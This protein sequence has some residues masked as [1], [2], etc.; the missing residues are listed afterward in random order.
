MIPR[1]RIEELKDCQVVVRHKVRNGA[2]LT[3]TGTLL[4]VYARRLKLET[5]GASGRYYHIPIRQVRSISPLEHVTVHNLEDGPGKA[6]KSPK[7]EVRI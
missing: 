7:E 6:L 5:S 1:A 3:H 4:N 2:I